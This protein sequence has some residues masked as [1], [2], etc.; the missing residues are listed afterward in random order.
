[1]AIADDTHVYRGRLPHLTRP[2]TTYF[3]TFCTASRRELLPADRDVVLAVCVDGH[4]TFYWLDCVNVMPDHVH[5][6]ITPYE[7]TTLPVVIGRIKGGSAFRTKR[8]GVWQRDY[9]DRIIRS[10]DDLAKKIEYIANNPVRKGLVERAEDWPWWWSSWS[11]GLYA[12]V[13]RAKARRST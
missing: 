10:D 13:R 8:G 2:G 1:V 4:Q 11:G 3:V 5:L 7:Q 6:I 12:A 9:F